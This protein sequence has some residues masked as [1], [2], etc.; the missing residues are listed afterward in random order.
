MR[1]IGRNRRAGCAGRRRGRVARL[2]EPE[3]AVVR[4]HGVAGQAVAVE[5]RGLEG[6]HGEE[7]HGGG[8]VDGSTCRLGVDAGGEATEGEEGYTERFHGG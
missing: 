1:A 3:V 6:L 4:G 7:T 2:R 5:V 8:D